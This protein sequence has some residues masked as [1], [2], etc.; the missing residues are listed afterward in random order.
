MHLILPDSDV[1]SEGLYLEQAE[2]EMNAMTNGDSDLPDAVLGAGVGT[3]VSR[4]IHGAIKRGDV[5]TTGDCQ[6][7]DANRRVIE[8]PPYP[9]ENPD[10]FPVKP[11]FS[12]LFCQ[13]VGRGGRYRAAWL[14][15]AIT[16]IAP[17]LSINHLFRSFCAYST[18]ASSFSQNRPVEKGLPLRA[19]LIPVLGMGRNQC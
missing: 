9:A 18:L 16:N 11:Q 1:V 14:C 13:E 7:G 8:S 19:L 6:G 15:L 17:G 12:V 5:P 10:V 2:V 3:G 4:R